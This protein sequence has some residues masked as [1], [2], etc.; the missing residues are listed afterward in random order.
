MRPTSIKSFA[1]V[2]KRQFEFCELKDAPQHKP[3]DAPVFLLLGP[4]IAPTLAL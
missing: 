1:L 3:S 2:F 4:W